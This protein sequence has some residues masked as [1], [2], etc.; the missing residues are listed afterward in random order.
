MAK[1]PIKRKTQQWTIPQ[2]GNIAQKERGWRNW[3][4]HYLEV[5]AAVRSWRFES[6]RA[7]NKN[8]GLFACLFVMCAGE[9]SK[10]GGSE[11]GTAAPP[12]RRVLRIVGPTLSKSTL[13]NPPYNSNSAFSR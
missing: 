4:T 2:I 12:R 11:G 8:T 6:L 7:H 13:I 3:Q 9:D 1:L 5:V 10:R